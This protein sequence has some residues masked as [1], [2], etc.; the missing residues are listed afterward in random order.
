MIYREKAMLAIGSVCCE[1]RSYQLPPAVRSLIK[2]TQRDRTVHKAVNNHTKTDTDV[3]PGHSL[4]LRLLSGGEDLDASGE[5]AR[6]PG[7]VIYPSLMHIAPTTTAG[8]I[9]SYAAWWTMPRQ[10]EN[11]QGKVEGNRAPGLWFTIDK[12]AQET[13]IPRTTLLRV[14]STLYTEHD[15]RK[16]P[17]GLFMP[18]FHP[19]AGKGPGRKRKWSLQLHWP[20]VFA[21]LTKKFGKRWAYPSMKQTIA[22]IEAEHHGNADRWRVRR[23]RHHRIGRHKKTLNSM[24]KIWVPHL[25]RVV[26]E[27]KLSTAIVLSELLY[28]YRQAMVP[29]S[30]RRS[31]KQRLVLHAGREWL[32]AGKKRMARIT[33]LSVDEIAAALQWLVARQIL[34]AGRYFAKDSCGHYQTTRHVRVN[35]A[36]L[37]SI[38]ASITE[39]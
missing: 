10:S 39:R 1:S 26:C 36:V 25:I 21:A 37:D 19:P 33:G 4:T 2:Y 23:I 24:P 35:F 27:G 13:L 11:C 7:L 18:R 3:K 6:V 15:G 28:W 30:M 31:K 8:A 32:A 29:P 34:I 17:R 12:I 20:R 22:S 5:L 9:Y 16:N 38:V 14:L